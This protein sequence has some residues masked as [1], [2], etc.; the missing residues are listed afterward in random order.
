MHP[1]VL[2]HGEIRPL[3]HGWLWLRFLPLAV[4]GFLPEATNSLVTGEDPFLRGY[5]TVQFTVFLFG[6][7]PPGWISP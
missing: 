5:V 1:E 6:L 4:C 2:L 7:T 3:C